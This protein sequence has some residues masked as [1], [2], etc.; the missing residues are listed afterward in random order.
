[1]IRRHLASL[2]VAIVA[3]PL[4]ASAGQ[5]TPQDVLAGTGATL[6]GPMIPLPHLGDGDIRRLDWVFERGLHARAPSFLELSVVDGIP[7]GAEPGDLPTW[8]ERCAFEANE[9]SLLAATAE[10]IH[11]CAARFFA[12]EREMSAAV[13]SGGPLRDTLPGTGLERLIEPGPGHE[14]RLPRELELVRVAGQRAAEQRAAHLAGILG[15]LPTASQGSD[16]VVAGLAHTLFAEAWFRLLG[17]HPWDAVEK[18]GEPFDG[19]KAACG[20]RPPAA[21]SAAFAPHQPGSGASPSASFAPGPWGPAPEAMALA[22]RLLCDRGVATPSA[23]DAAA[24]LASEATVQVL[25]GWADLVLRPMDW[26][27]SGLGIEAPGSSPVGRTDARLRLGDASEA[28]RILDAARAAGPGPRELQILQLREAQAHLLLGDQS[29]ALEAALGGRDPRSVCEETE[30][31]GGAIPALV[32]PK[33][34][35][36]AQVLGLDLALPLAA[37]DGEALRAIGCLAGT[38]GDEF[39]ED[40]TWDFLRMAATWADVPGDADRRLRGIL[41]GSPPA[42]RLP[43]SDGS[44][45]A[46]ETLEAEVARWRPAEVG[47]AESSRS[48]IAWSVVAEVPGDHSTCSHVALIVASDHFRSCFDPQIRALGLRRAREAQLR[49]WSVREEACWAELSA[50]RVGLGPKA[51][52]RRAEIRARCEDLG[53]RRPS[54]VTWEALSME[55]AAIRGERLA[56]PDE[57]T[58]VADH[59]GVEWTEDPGP[60]GMAGPDRDGPPSDGLSTNP[61]E[62][63]EQQQRPEPGVRYPEL[64]EAD[65][66]A[67]LRGPIDGG[68]LWAFLA[69]SEV[70][71]GLCTVVTP[72]HPPDADLR[73]DEAFRNWLGTDVVRP[74]G[75]GMAESWDEDLFDRWHAAAATWR[76]DAGALSGRSPGRMPLPAGLAGR[77]RAVLLDR[78]LHRD[79]PAREE[80]RERFWWFLDRHIHDAPLRGGQRTGGDGTTGAPTLGQSRP[81]PLDSD[82]TEAGLGELLDRRQALDLTRWLLTGLGTSGPDVQ[83]L[84]EV[85]ES[86]ASSGSL[87]R[88]HP[89]F[90]SVFLEVVQDAFRADLTERA[91]DFLTTPPRLDV[92]VLGVERYFGLH[93]QFADL[94]A[95]LVKP[96]GELLETIYAGGLP[97]PRRVEEFSAAVLQADRQFR[98]ASEILRRGEIEIQRAARIVPDGGTEKALQLAMAR[99]IGDLATALDSVGEHAKANE[100][101]IDHAGYQVFGP[102]LLVKPGRVPAM[103]QFVRDPGDRS[104]LASRW[105]ELLAEL[106]RRSPGEFGWAR[107]I[108]ARTLE[109]QTSYLFGYPVRRAPGIDDAAYLLVLAQTDRRKAEDWLGAARWLAIDRGLPKAAA[110]VLYESRGVGGA[111]AEREA[112]DAAWPWASALRQVAG[113]LDGPSR[114]AATRAVPA[115]TAALRQRSVEAAR[116]PLAGSDYDARLAAQGEVLAELGDGCVAKRG[117]ADGFCALDSGTLW[118]DLEVLRWAIERHPESSNPVDLE[119][120][121]GAALGRASRV[122][123]RLAS[124]AREHGDSDWRRSDERL[125][126]LVEQV[127]ELVPAASHGHQDCRRQLAGVWTEI[128]G[129]SEGQLGPYEAGMV[130]EEDR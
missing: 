52:T 113:M 58:P 81:D 61:G 91:R 106:V 41:S 72:S 42:T 94:L 36:T 31:G 3:L 37:L 2:A 96:S 101:V 128:Q 53:A 87:L 10:A 21:G 4:L 38:E 6:A 78:T 12:L 99:R 88:S 112:M 17:A 129:L 114:E 48:W 60:D 19:P 62:G 97:E 54:E 118:L 7:S 89:Q 65:L 47:E 5:V 43:L 125:S 59:C 25:S 57:E 82:L 86:V 77:L 69:P 24:L 33:P 13:A 120:S 40:P 29:S 130:T 20:S 83:Y 79:D 22:R 32:L 98:N 18:G 11:S 27:Q 105:A 121:G 116:I 124:R 90:P 111:D 108:T 63:A 51:R 9:R 126:L 102:R 74:S 109:D 44:V 122:A 35:S 107:G 115:L 103:L 110:S 92:E 30:Q 66:A 84:D 45:V 71:E 16:A 46:A 85:L 117:M 127:T 55:V 15:L 73:Q 67:R 70:R 100:L 80:A 49:A 50:L 68:D 39:E 123:D 28:L 119:A 56:R 93:L 26:F 64:S 34:P 76:G 104:R 1:M 75:S 14:W 8:E 23:A 95:G